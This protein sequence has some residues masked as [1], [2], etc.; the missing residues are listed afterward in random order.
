MLVGDA[1]CGLMARSGDVV[2]VVEEDVESGVGIVAARRENWLASRY[3]DIFRGGTEEC[4]CRNWEAMSA[5]AEDEGGV[6]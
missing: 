4:F 5:A 3:W 2:V 1:G 6:L